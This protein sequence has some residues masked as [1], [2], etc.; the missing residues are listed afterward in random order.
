MA[1]STAEIWE[2]IGE[3]PRSALLEMDAAT[4]Q[5]QAAVTE[6]EALR[7][8]RQRELAKAQAAA[9]VTLDADPKKV[10]TA[11][12]LITSLTAMLEEIDAELNNRRKVAQVAAQAASRERQRYRA[13]LGHIAEVDAE[14]GKLAKKRADLQ[15]K[16]GL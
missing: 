11:Q 1:I 8:G 2:H 13:I 3:G 5:A 16:L 12:G 10:A 15:G 9:A 4:E 14:A 6:L 7:D